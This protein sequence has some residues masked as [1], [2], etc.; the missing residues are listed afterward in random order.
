MLQMP[1]VGPRD[2]K[3]QID[4]DWFGVCAG[5]HST[6]ECTDKEA[7]GV[8]VAERCINCNEK[9]VRAWHKDCSKRLSFISDSTLKQEKSK[10]S[11]ISQAAR[12][13]SLS[14][15]RP[16]PA[17]GRQGQSNA[18]QRRMDQEE[19]QQKAR[20]DHRDEGAETTR[21]DRHDLMTTTPVT[22]ISDRKEL[23]TRELVHK[24]GEVF[25]K[26]MPLLENIT[27]ELTKTVKEFRKK[28]CKN[29]K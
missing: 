4:V 13:V 16:L 22:N 24:I 29:L 10:P 18:W 7:Q 1:E 6:Q 25:H 26:V 27:H 23:D 17:S 14:N 9:G 11:Q 3:V 28:I 5:R 21:D 8:T 20:S 12:N 2:P 19:Q 15:E